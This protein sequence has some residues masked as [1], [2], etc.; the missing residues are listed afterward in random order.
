MEVDLSNF[1]ELNQVELAI[2]AVIG[3]LLLFAGY[4]VKKVAFFIIW[5]I[6]GFTLM[7]Y[8][9]PTINTWAP[10]IAANDLWQNLLP[11]VGGLLLAL[12]GFTIEKLCVGGIAFG[13]TLAVTA[14]YFGTEVQTLVIGGVIG[15][16]AAGA[17]VVLMKPAI[18]VLTSVAGAYALTVGILTWFPAISAAVFYFPILAGLALIGIVVQFLT[19]KHA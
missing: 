13:L 14:Q 15:V 4:R 8:L 3:A 5:F 10:E 2:M 6:L 18:I 1:S 11:L 19:T 7:G 12:L 17:A 9:M 16:I